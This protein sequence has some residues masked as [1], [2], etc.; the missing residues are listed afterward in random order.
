L[1]A[2]LQDTQQVL[3]EIEIRIAVFLRARVMR[4]AATGQHGYSPLALGDN[5]RDRAPE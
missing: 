1:V 3:I 2:T 4:H 5:L